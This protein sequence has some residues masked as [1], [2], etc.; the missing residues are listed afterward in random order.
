M[1]HLPS[2]RAALTGAV[3]C[4]ASA[5]ALAADYTFSGTTDAGP[6]S[7]TVFS[8][9]FSFDTPVADG[10]VALTAFALDFA[11]QAYGLEIDSYA[12]FVGGNLIGLNYADLASADTAV[13]PHVQFEATDW[14]G[15][16]FW[17]E[18]AAGA[19]GFGSYGISAVPEPQTYALLL[20]GLGV[21]AAR[22]R[23]RS[24]R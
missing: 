8:G 14:S 1:N 7:G 24:G 4:L 11:G 15:A 23:R 16:H 13:R 12:T 6:L 10:D 17:Y 21:I 20:A 19:T 9:S 3:L 22:Q 5:G 2:I 18:G